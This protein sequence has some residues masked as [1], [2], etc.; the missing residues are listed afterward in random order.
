MDHRAL[1]LL[2]FWLS[3]TLMSILGFILCPKDPQMIPAISTRLEYPDFAVSAPDGRILTVDRGDKRIICIDGK[4]RVIW[5]RFGGKR[6]PRDFYEIWRMATDREGHIY[7]AN[8]IYDAGENR[9][10]AEEIQEWDPTGAYLRTL[11]KKE[12]PDPEGPFAI[13]GRIKEIQVLENQVYYWYYEDENTL[14]LFQTGNDIPLL[15]VPAGQEVIDIALL[16]GMEAVFTTKAGHLIAYH[17]QTGKRD[18]TPGDL[19]VPWGIG[20]S[21]NAVLVTDMTQAGIGRYNLSGEWLWRPLSRYPDAILRQAEFREDGSWIAI[22]DKSSSLIELSSDGTS[23]KSWNEFP[24]SLSLSLLKLTPWFFLVLLCLSLVRFF[25]ALYF[26]ILRRRISLMIKWPLFLLPIY[27]GAMVLIAYQTYRETHA[28]NVKELTL[29]LKTLAQLGSEKIDGNALER[30]NRPDDYGKPDYLRLQN[31]LY[32][33]LNQQSDP[34][35][36]NLYALLYKVRNGRYYYT[37]DLSGYYGSIYPYPYV[38]PAHRLAYESNLISEAS[39]QDMEGEWLIAAA[40]VTNLLGQTTGILEVGLN[41]TLSKENQSLIVNKL[42]GIIVLWTFFFLLILVMVTFFLMEA[43]LRLNHGVQSV[44]SGDLSVNIHVES[45]DEIADLAKGFNEM[46]SQIRLNLNRYQTLNRSL[47]DQVASRTEELETERNKLQKRN[48]AMESDLVL[49]R[50]IQKQ[51]LPAKSP[52]SHIAF[53]YKPMELI[54]G[55]FFDF[56]DLPERHATAIFVS[57]VSG[58]G[59]PAAFLTAMIKSILMQSRSLQDQ[60][61]E[62][63]YLLNDSLQNLAGGNFVTALYGIYEPE[64]GRFTYS[65]AGHPCPILISGGKV[66]PVNHC[67]GGFPLAILPGSA[68]RSGNKQ[69]GKHTIQLKPGD[70][71][72]LYTDGLTESTGTESS[73]D[74]ETALLTQSCHEFRNLSADL[75]VAELYLRLADFHGSDRFEDDVC[76]ICLDV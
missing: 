69:Y 53:V 28:E 41:L 48:E 14:S 29:R 12:Y 6:G 43:I 62:M 55:D 3:L 21:S 47:E 19:S 64:N 71:L 7:L 36:E 44:A 9:I 30:I 56:I 15:R 5:E 67:P 57:D 26:K 11:V 63:L 23:Q 16:S 68:I 24:F 49:A 52:G 18:I 33:I 39:Y 2:L 66:F 61:D 60:P 4:R 74:F 76:L 20:P 59:V 50:R 8:G 75:F 38:Q 25:W 22:D 31:S 17:P 13:S 65:S 46:T 32:S 37:V 54:G 10:I 27:I 72:L 51:I 34:W 73:E 42:I 35:N 58:H 1:K 70:K 45:H 40:P